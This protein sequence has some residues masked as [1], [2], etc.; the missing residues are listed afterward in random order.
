M[1]STTDLHMH[2]R[3]SDGT[4]Y[5]EELVRK[6]QDAG[7]RTFA[8]TDHDTIDGALQVKKM[9]PDGITY[10]LGIE[11]T[12]MTSFGEVHILGYNFDPENAIFQAVLE[13]GKRLRREKLDRRID[14]LKKQGVPVTETEID[15]FHRMKSCGKPHLANMIVT[16][17]LAKNKNEAIRRYIDP[18]DCDD[19]KITSAEAIG[20]VNEAGGISVWAHPLGEGYGR[21]RDGRGRFDT[22]EQCYAKLQE[23]VR[24]GIIGM[25]CFYSQ[26][27]QSQIDSLRQTAEAYHL[28]VS[29][30]SDYHGENKNIALGQLNAAQKDVSDDDLSILREFTR[31]GLKA[32][33]DLERDEDDI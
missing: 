31:R 14:W 10:Y 5:P 1:A 8:V 18:C 26:Y 27:S 3:A 22:M 4:D 23:L 17:G 6:I 16:K 32:A 24:Q 13:K 25:E 29:G 7:I 2:T 15:A 19:L 30:G 33:K 28:C 9:V 12:T 21:P 20:A 11:F